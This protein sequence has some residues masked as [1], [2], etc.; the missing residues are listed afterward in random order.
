MIKVDLIIPSIL[1]YHKY[2]KFKKIDKLLFFQKYSLPS[3]NGNW[4]PI[5]YN[6][7]NLK[8]KGVKIRFL[9]YLNF[10]HK[11]LSN[12]VGFDSRI[13]NNLI[14]KY[15]SIKET[16]R[17]GII[18]LLE[19]LKKKVDYLLFFD[20]ADSTGH[21]HYEVFSYV[22]RYF[23]KQLLKDRTLYTKPLYRKRL[24]TDFYASNYFSDKKEYTR[25][26]H[27]L[28]LKYQQKLGLSWNFALKDYRYST[29]L[30]RFLYGL[31]RKN[32]LNFH[33][34]NINREITLAA[35]FTIKP[36]HELVYFQRNQLLKILKKMYQSN[37]KI[38]LGKIPKN[39]YIKT[40]R[41]SKAIISPYGWG[42][43]C[44]RDFETYLAGAA[45]IKPNMD[46]I[47]TWPNIY[48]KYE[49]YIP[50]PWKIEEW[51]KLIPNILSDEQL[52]LK[53]AYNGQKSFKKIWTREG[54]E[55]FCDHFI[56][57]V[58]PI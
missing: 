11:S 23:K 26:E 27:I 41:S 15:G 32:N 19:Q 33:K 6:L 5:W 24:F 29:I 58:N 37:P 44:Y 54:N 50:I 57:M 17:N 14:I 55:I 53:V 48:K 39:I 43:I 18:P 31:T 51:E 49:T 21:F 16:L 34:P 47:D 12:I 3:W 25:N 38:S 8:K 4:Y 2:P 36:L 1:S 22:D 28:D 45:L 30:S 42:E 20:N 46:H 40:M 10:N 35:N 9:N 7:K 13:I 52:L 56:E